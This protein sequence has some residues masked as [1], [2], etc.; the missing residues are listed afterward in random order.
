MPENKCAELAADT[1]G[2]IFDI[3]TWVTGRPKN[4]AKF[5]KVFVKVIAD[6]GTPADCQVCECRADD[7]GVG[8]SI[9][10]RCLEEELP[11]SI[12]IGYHYP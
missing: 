2:S 5:V 3:N 1:D 6:K 4:A 9:C 8:I 12:S 7:D 11:V 10:S